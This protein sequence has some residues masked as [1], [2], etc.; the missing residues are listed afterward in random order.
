MQNN[1]NKRGS[2]VFRESVGGESNVKMG[3]WARLKAGIEKSIE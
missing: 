2:F 3:V 1:N